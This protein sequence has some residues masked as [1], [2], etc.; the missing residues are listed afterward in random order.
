MVIYNTLTRK[1]EKFIPREPGKVFI[2]VCGPTT[3]HYIHIG[4]ARPL[5]FFDTVRRYFQYKG[6]QVK[7]V[8]NFTDI[9]DKIIKRALEEGEEPL[10][11]SQR[12]VVEYFQDADALN[13]RRADI[14]PKVTEHMED[15]IGLVEILVNKGAAYIVN[16]DVYF[17]LNSFPDYGKLS[18]RSLA[19]MLVGARVEVDPRKKNPLDFALWKASRPGEPSW[20]SPWG[21]GRP[22]WHIECSAM[23]LKYLGVNFDL[24][25]GGMDLIFPHHENEIA[26]AEA[27]TGKPFAR[28]WIHNGF[29]NVNQEKMSKSQG[30][31]FLVREVLKKFSPLVIRFFLLATHY[32]SPLDFDDEKIIAAGRGWER[33]KNSIRL[34]NNALNRQLRLETCDQD[35]E[36][37]AKLENIRKQFEEALDD[38]FNTA[39]AI[40]FYFELAKEANTYL[41]EEAIPC[42]DI[43]QKILALFMNFNEI[44]GLFKTDSQAKIFLGDQP[45]KGDELV[46]SLIELFLQF[47]QEAREKKDWATADRI[48]DGLKEQGI[49]IEDTLY[50]TRWKIDR[51]E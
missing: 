25:G 46:Q 29:L 11:L 43:L 20:P 26:Q 37:L 23:S 12:Y 51:Q 32:R 50:G 35:R 7:Y 34:V 9:D 47:R 5:V 48:R 4:N 42:K 22:G 38:D 6:Y 44:L 18:R 13:V 15:I 36:R 28:Y 8:Q 2:Y 24:H 21:A 19:E 14:H 3:Y 10:K 1:K 39:L 41:Q 49:L 27:A 40:S 17:D 31:F 16:G 30:N 45:K 33:L